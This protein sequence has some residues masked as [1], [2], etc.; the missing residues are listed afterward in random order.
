MLVLDDALVKFL[1]SVGPAM[2]L[3]SVDPAMLAIMYG[4]RHFAHVSRP[5][6]VRHPAHVEH[7]LNLDL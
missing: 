2:V 1:L 4:S 7:L 6:H 5:A 3:L